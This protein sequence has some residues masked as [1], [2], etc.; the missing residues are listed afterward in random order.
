MF[1]GLFLL[2]VESAMF[3]DHVLVALRHLLYLNAAAA[4]NVCRY[5]KLAVHSLE[6]IVWSFKFIV[7]PDFEL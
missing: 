5:N 2:T 7:C 3:I 6:F 4:P 1:A